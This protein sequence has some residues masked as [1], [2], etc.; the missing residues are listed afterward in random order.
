VTQGAGGWIAAPV[1]AAVRAW[2]AGA[3]ASRVSRAVRMRLL[4]RVAGDV[5]ASAGVGVGSGL[6]HGLVPFVPEAARCF[7]P[8]GETGVCKRKGGS[9]GPETQRNCRL[10]KFRLSFWVEAP[11]SALRGWPLSL[12]KPGQAVS[13]AKRTLAEREGPEPHTSQIRVRVMTLFCFVSKKR[14]RSSWGHGALNMSALIGVDTLLVARSDGEDG[15]VPFMHRSVG[16]KQNSLMVSPD[17]LSRDFASGCG[18]PSRDCFF[19]EPHRK[20]LP[21]HIRRLILRLIRN[22]VFWLWE[23][24]RGAMIELVR[25]GFRVRRHTSTCHATVRASGAPTLGNRSLG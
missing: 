4:L 11:W 20:S 24:C 8:V 13:A 22:A 17:E 25:H 12:A 15:P 16:V 9:Q 23:I 5:G 10:R 19:G 2:R 14:Y 21:P 6:A 7:L 1:V 3:R 18:T